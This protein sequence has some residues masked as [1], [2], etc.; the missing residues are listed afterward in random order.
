MP[1]W[2]FADL[3]WSPRR[4]CP[5]HCA[6]YTLLLNLTDLGVRVQE[7][8]LLAVCCICRRREKVRYCAVSELV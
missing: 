4:P 1:S 8:V 7:A 3:I 5:S 6:G 2:G